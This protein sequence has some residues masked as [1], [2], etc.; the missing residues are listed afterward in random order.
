MK[1]TTNAGIIGTYYPENLRSGDMLHVRADGVLSTAT[2]H[3]KGPAG[4]E[5]ISFTDH[6]DITVC[7][8]TRVV[9]FA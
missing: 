5:I 1:T 6:A 4:T 7:G 8:G 2:T 9:V 3:R